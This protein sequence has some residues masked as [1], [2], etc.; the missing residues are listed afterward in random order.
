[1]VETGVLLVMSLILAL[2]LP[3][4]DGLEPYQDLFLADALVPGS[5]TGYGGR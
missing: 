4:R 1:M 2:A 3:L 5:R